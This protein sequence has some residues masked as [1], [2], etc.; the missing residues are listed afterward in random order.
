MNV[1]SSR[2]PVIKDNA[3][4]ISSK[5]NYRHIGLASVI[6]KL[7]EVIM[8]DSIE[9]YMNTN[10]NQF[11]FKRK[12]G[13][14]QCI[15]FLKEIIDLYRRL[16]GSVFVCFLY[17]SNAFDRV[18]HGTLFKQLGARSVPGYILRIIIYWYKNQDMGIRWG[19][20]Y[21]A[22]LKVTNSV[23]QGE[24]LSPYLFNGYVDELS[25]E[26]N[27]CNVGCNLNGH[28]INHIMYADD[29]VL[30]SPSSA[31][32]SQLLHECE[33]FGTRHDLKYN[34]KTSAVMIYRSMILKGCTIPKLKL[35]GII[36]HVVASYK[37]LGHYITDD[38]SD[39]DDDDD[40]DDDINRQRR[41]LFV[42]GNI[43]LRMFNMCSLGVKLT[44]FPTYWSPMY[45]AQLWWNYK[46]LPLQNC[47]LLIIT[48]F[49][50]FLACPKYE[51]TSYLCTLFDIQC[52]QSVIRKLVY[53]FMCRLD[54]SANCIIQFVLA[55]SLRYTSRIRKHWCSLLYINS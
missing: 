7:V 16:N 4:K 15:Y 48:F 13:T 42:Q 23:R 5:D 55:T 45:T 50:C 12:H 44:P 36:L 25:E 31:G 2:G 52:C 34:A 27:K 17:A 47:K 19:D 46:N 40:D 9:M 20:A 39:D 49:K 35:N 21:S 38:L 29:L 24:I 54:S 22:K 43:I 18:N 28:I 3:G 26:L 41:T 51:S 53:E 14:D 33:K 8:L 32:L 10:P 30:I 37:Y 6:S 11:G 1:V